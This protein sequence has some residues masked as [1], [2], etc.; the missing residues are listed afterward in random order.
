MDEYVMV[1]GV[2]ETVTIALAM[3]VIIVLVTAV[4]RLLRT[5]E[6]M[7]GASASSLPSF[8]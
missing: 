4:T 5:S 6:V 1:L 7:D 2:A 3:A 8:F